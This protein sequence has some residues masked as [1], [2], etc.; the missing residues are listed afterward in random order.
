ML[1]TSIDGG[2]Q[3]RSILVGVQKVASGTHQIA[4]TGSFTTGLHALQRVV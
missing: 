3:S 4:G 1:K 2:I